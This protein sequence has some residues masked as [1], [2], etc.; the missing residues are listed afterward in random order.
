ML[1]LDGAASFFS[2]FFGV[3]GLP[4]IIFLSWDSDKVCVHAILFIT[5]LWDF[6]EFVVVVV[7]NKLTLPNIIELS[8][9]FFIFFPLFYVFLL[10][11]YSFTLGP[12]LAWGWRRK[13]KGFILHKFLCQS[14]R[15][16][17]FPSTYKTLLEN[18]LSLNF[19]CPKSHFIFFYSN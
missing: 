12:R 4:K 11:S 3:E 7:V 15:F 5:Y 17:Q 2:Y 14:E 10:L 8:F 6:I 9:L 1:L 13:K 19:I 18:I 16:L